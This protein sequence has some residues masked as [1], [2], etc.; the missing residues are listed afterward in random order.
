MSF[1]SSGV[2]S[3]TTVTAF[4]RNA[5]TSGC[6]CGRS[7]PARRRTSRSRRPTSR[8]EAAC[9]RRS[10]GYR[11]RS[12][13]RST[14][15]VGPAPVARQRR[16]RRRRTARK[17]VGHQVAAVGLPAAHALREAE[18]GALPGSRSAPPPSERSAVVSVLVEARR[19][20]APPRSAE[21][22]C[23]RRHG[24]TD[25]QVR[26]LRP[27][28]V[29]T[30]TR[31]GKLLVSSMTSVD[32]PVRVELQRRC[33]RRTCSCPPW[34]RCSTGPPSA[35]TSLSGRSPRSPGLARQ[36]LHLGGSAS[37]ASSSS[38]PPAIGDVA[39]RARAYQLLVVVHVLELPNEHDP[40]D[41]RLP[42]SRSIS[43]LHDC[44]RRCQVRA[45]AVTFPGEEIVGSYGVVTPMIPNR[46]PVTSSTT[47]MRPS[48]DPAL[49]GLPCDEAVLAAS[50]RQRRLLAHVEVRRQERLGRPSAPKRADE[51][52]EERPGPKSNSW[53]PMMCTS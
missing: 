48:D 3:R 13:R 32:L 24:I 12:A 20:P 52:S 4:D 27:V 35:S 29:S 42:V 53:L 18:S 16:R 7:G 26:D 28:L 14:L 33:G 47:I 6:P 31:H 36:E 1:N 50:F 37:L 49:P 38:P 41:L 22:A 21:H 2:T 8:R 9:S 5:I 39:A 25:T 11:R 45:S 15:V 23:V 17:R 30:T 46:M 44:R 19:P 10:G 40:L 34:S 51:A 43:C